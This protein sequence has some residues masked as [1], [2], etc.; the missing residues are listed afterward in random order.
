MSVGTAVKTKPEGVVQVRGALHSDSGHVRLCAALAESFPPQ[1]TAPS[2]RVHGVHLDSVPGLQTSP[3]RSILWADSVVVEGRI[4]DGEL[5][6][7][8]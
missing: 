3:D 1:C 4:V 6:I 8:S 7:G 2:L 5:S